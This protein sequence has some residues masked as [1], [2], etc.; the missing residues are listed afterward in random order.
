MKQDQVLAYFAELIAEG[1]H[2]VGAERVPFL[3][4][5]D[6]CWLR[7]NCTIPSRLPL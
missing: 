1:H 3:T 4:T 5:A 7:R 2:L 6:T